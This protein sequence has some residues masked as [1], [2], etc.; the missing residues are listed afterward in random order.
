VELGRIKS[1][2]ERRQLQLREYCAKALRRIRLNVCRNSTA[3]STSALQDLIDRIGAEHVERRLTVENEHESQLFGQGLILFNLENWYSAPSIVRTALKLTGLYGRARRNAD[4]IVIRRNVLDFA[5]LPTAFEN[6]TILHLSDLHVDISEGAMQRLRGM[7]SDLQ[8][9]ICVLTGDY[10]GKTYGPFEASLQGISELK[11][12]L[13][14]PLYAV[15]GNHDSIRM[16]PSLEAMGIRM[17]FNECDTIARGNDRIYIY[18]AGIDDA[19]F[20]RADDIDKAAKPIPQGAFS[21]LL[22]HT[23][24]IYDGAARAGFDIML[25]GHTHGGQ[26]CLPGGVPIKLE[27]RLPRRMGAGL[28]Q[29]FGMAGYTS[30]GVGTSLLPVRLN[31]PPEIT[32]HTFRRP[33]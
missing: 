24:E 2:T 23:P 31:Y 11:A 5:N 32:L 6:F 1:Q 17:L 3:V 21:I 25:S 12:E 9:D 26:L 13:K 19:H 33:R 4:Q 27:A 29:H 16:A 28:W 8:Y 20:Y 15:L 30:V 7:V 14:G 18:L 10:R 22:S